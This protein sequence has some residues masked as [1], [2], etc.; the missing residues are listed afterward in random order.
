M[1]IKLSRGPGSRHLILLLFCLGI[2]S[3]GDGQQTTYGEV[4]ERFNQ[5]AHY[6]RARA[7]ARESLVGIYLERSVEMIIGLLANLCCAELSL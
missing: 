5:L 3:A 4:K 6:V 1:Q 7:G 2:F